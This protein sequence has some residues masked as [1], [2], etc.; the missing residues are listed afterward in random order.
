MAPATG[1][2]LVSS[3]RPSMLPAGNPF[4]PG[5]AVDCAYKPVAP[6]RKTAIAAAG[7]S[8]VMKTLCCELRSDGKRNVARHS[9]AVGLVVDLQL[10]LVIARLETRKRNPL[11]DEDLM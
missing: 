6:I 4:R 10:H 9:R 5:R 7:T 8:R 3:T 1:A 2:S 11:P